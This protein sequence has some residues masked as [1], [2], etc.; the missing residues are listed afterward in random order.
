MNC[1]DQPFLSLAQNAQRDIT[2]RT[3]LQRAGGGIGLAAL[4]GLL[5]G[6]AQA[7]GTAG[8]PGFPNGLFVTQDGYNDDLNGMDGEVAATNF[9]YVDWA[10]IAGSFA[11][12]LEVNPGFD[13]RQ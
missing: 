7:A 11:P 5:G 12:P 2:R 4:G 3:F 1:N 10:M 9:K 6:Q 13:P 8:L